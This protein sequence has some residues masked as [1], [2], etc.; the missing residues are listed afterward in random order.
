ME[1]L[2]DFGNVM[3]SFLAGLDWS[4]I[5]TFL[6]TSWLLLFAGKNVFKP[7]KGARFLGLRCRQSFVVLFIGIAIAILWIYFDNGLRSKT[8]IKALLQSYLFAQV[9]HHLFL[10]DLQEK[11]S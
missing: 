2:F 8:Y 4:Y 9:F 3:A 7:L 5:I 11:L 6:I 10:R 1:K